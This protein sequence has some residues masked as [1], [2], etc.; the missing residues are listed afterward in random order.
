MSDRTEHMRYTD[1]DAPWRHVYA[2][3]YQ[4]QPAI[5]RGNVAALTALREALDKAIAT[6]EATA[7]AFAI[8]G[9]G[10]GILCQRVNLNG[11]LGPLPYCDEPF[12]HERSQFFRGAY[13][14][15]D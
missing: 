13:R 3:I 6:G 7:D 2:Q 4:H 8:D 14:G 9:E 15:D 10:F 1:P 12:P 5:I 11:L